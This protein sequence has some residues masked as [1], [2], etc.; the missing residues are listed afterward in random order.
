MLAELP[1]SMPS[2]HVAQKQERLLEVAS[3]ASRTCAHSGVSGHAHCEDGIRPV[4][5]IR[6]DIHAEQRRASERSSV[7]PAGF[8]GFL[9]DVEFLDEE[10]FGISKMEA[11]MM[12]PQQF[13]LLDQASQALCNPAHEVKRTV[14]PATFA[15]YAACYTTDYGKLLCKV[16]E[17]AKSPYVGSGVALSVVA[18]RLSYTF[19]AQGPA[20][21]VDTACSSSLVATHM[22]YQGWDLKGVNTA[23]VCG[24]CVTIDVGITTAVNDAS[25]LASDGRCKTLDTSADGYVRAEAC[26]SVLL[27]DSPAPQRPS[28]TCVVGSAVNQ[29]GRSSS[30][31]APNGPAQQ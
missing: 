31:T 28:A 30:L 20:V 14:P 27:A 15:V 29:D 21:T 16:P 11:G 4:P 19:G 12:D 22:A 9:Q 26:V 3:V 18:G 8:G 2:L 6:W 13:L 17:A 25:M 10:H 23:L 7:L 5:L 24:V 1:D